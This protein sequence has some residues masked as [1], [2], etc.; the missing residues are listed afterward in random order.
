MT[1]LPSVGFVVKIRFH[2]FFCGRFQAI[3]RF[4]VL[5][6]AFHVMRERSI[7][8]IDNPSNPQQPIQ[9]PIPETEKSETQLPQNFVRHLRID[10][11][12]Q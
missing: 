5:A 7:I 9:Q 10:S 4:D 11:Q 12:E 2:L 1:T 8:M 3:F 6:G